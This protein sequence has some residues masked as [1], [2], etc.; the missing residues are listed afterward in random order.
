MTF[1]QRFDY[2]LLPESDTKRLGIALS[3]EAWTDNGAI[4]E[5]VY[6]TEKNQIAFIEVYF[7]PSLA[8]PNGRANG[9]YTQDYYEIGLPIGS[10]AAANIQWKFNATT[11]HIENA[12]LY[13]PDQLYISFASSEHNV[14]EPSETPDVRCY[15]GLSSARRERRNRFI[16]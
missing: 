2:T 4:I 8:L 16:N 15:L 11:A 1:L 3:P 7:P 6:N 10:G 13:N 14:D 12:T 5:I 9:T